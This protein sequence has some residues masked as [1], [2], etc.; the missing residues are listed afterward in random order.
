MGD[1]TAVMMDVVTEKSGHQ[2]TPLAVSVCLT[3]AAPSPLPIPYPVTASSGEG[4]TDP[5]MRTKVGGAPVAT[6][7]S[8]LKACHGNEPG[9][10]KEVVSFNTG[11]PSFLVMG[12]PTV[13]C[14]LGMMGITGSPGFHNKQ[15]TV[16]APANASDA[17]GSAGAGGS[18]AVAGSG[19]G[20]AQKSQGPSQNAGSSGASNASG[21]SASP[22]HAELAAEE[23]K[24]PDD[25]RNAERVA[26]RKHVAREFYSKHGMKYDGATGKNRNFELPREMGEIEDHMSG[27]DFDKPVKAGPPPSMPKN[28]NQVHVPERKGQYFAPAGVTPEQLSV[29]R[30]GVHPKTGA[31]VAK[32]TDTY[33]MHPDSPYLVTTASKKDDTWSVRGK[34][35]PGE[36]GG[37]QYYVPDQSKQ[38]NLTGSP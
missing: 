16:G 1:V 5:A 19:G 14:E 36:G 29:G 4:I 10:L 8:C 13:I 2:M 24:T 11:G 22:A 31:E 12:A 6:V 38:K 32:T 7:G 21:A 20:D 35:Q 26:A 25:G 9:T 3:P 18:G 15:V 28:L 34:T 17:D 30:Q 23:N 27:I 33:E 37:T